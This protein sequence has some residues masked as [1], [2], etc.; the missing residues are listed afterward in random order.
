MSLTN[1]QGTNPTGPTVISTA[2][3][4]A[5][6]TF[7]TGT[8]IYGEMNILVSGIAGGTV[9]TT[10]RSFDGTTYYDVP[11]GEFTADDQ[12][13]ACE[14]EPDVYWRAGV[15]TGDYGSGTVTIRISK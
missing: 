4:S 11:D 3:I 12:V 7:T 2:S 8:K 13:I 5:E 15:K 9:V 6:N 1:N 14:V 10:Q